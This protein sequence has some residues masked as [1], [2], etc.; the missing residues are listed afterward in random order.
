MSLHDMGSHLVMIGGAV[1]EEQLENR[2]QAVRR[3]DYPMCANGMP[4]TC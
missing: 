1:W 4:M 2:T 3:Y